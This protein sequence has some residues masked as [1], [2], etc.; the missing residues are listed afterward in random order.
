MTTRM[1]MSM[2]TSMSMSMTTSMSMSMTTSMIMLTK[3][4]ITD[5]HMGMLTA[6]PREV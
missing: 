6:Y 1:S 2:T 4:M 3:H 5:T